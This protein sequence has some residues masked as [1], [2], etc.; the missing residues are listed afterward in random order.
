MSD[1]PKRGPGRP[2]HEVTR[3]RQQLVQVLKANGN[4]H[5]TI[6]RAMGINRDTLEIHYREQLN[7]GHEQVKASVGAAVVRMAMA[8][9]ISAARFWLACHGGPEWKARVEEEGYSGGQTTIIIKG[10]LPK[11]EHDD[12]PEPAKLNGHGNGHDHAD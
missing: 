10:G 12:E 1:L 3:E 5:K 4:S 2:Q 11:I 7:H 8:G 9:N 6:A